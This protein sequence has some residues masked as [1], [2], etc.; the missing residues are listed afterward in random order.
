MKTAIS[1]QQ[2]PGILALTAGRDKIQLGVL[3]LHSPTMFTPGHSTFLYF[4]LTASTSKDLKQYKKSRIIIPTLFF[5]ILRLHLLT[6]QRREK[7]SQKLD[8]H[9]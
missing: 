8:I 1:G 3:L 4:L 5:L 7:W 9:T 6:E 2:Q